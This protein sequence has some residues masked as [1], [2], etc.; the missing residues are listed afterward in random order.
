MFRKIAARMPDSRIDERDTM[1]ARMGRK[2]NT[3]PYIDYYKNNE[4]LKARDDHIRSLTPL[5]EKGSKY[6]D[7]D[8]SN[9]AKELFDK[10]DENIYH[11]INIFLEIL[12]GHGGLLC[13]HT[14]SY[15]KS[16]TSPLP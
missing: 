14:I 11:H 12:Y 9:Q 2:Q 13:Q 5:F 4:D 8:L 16:V 3:L 7:L 15:A 1:F 6:F 10:I